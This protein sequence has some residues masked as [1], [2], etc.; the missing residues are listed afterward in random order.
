M[1]VRR[2]AREVADVAAQAVLVEGLDDGGLVDDLGAGEVEQDGARLHERELLHGDHAVGRV[3]ERH[4]DGE[5]VGLLEDLVHVGG[6]LDVGGQLPGVLDRHGRVEADDVEAEAEGRV[7][8]LDADGAQADDAEGAAGQLEA[9]ELLLAGLDGL[10]HGVSV[11]VVEL[12]GVAGRGDEVAGGDE[13][14]REDELLDSVRVGAGRVEDR[15][16]ELGH[17]GDRDVVRAG[18]G[19]AD[20]EQG[21]GNLHVVQLGG[22]DEEGGGLLDAGADLVEGVGEA[23]QA[24]AVDRVE[25]LDLEGLVSHRVSPG[26]EGFARRVR[27]GC[28]RTRPCTR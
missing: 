9:L 3:D 6:A 14:A 19:A 17:P 25:G 13:D 20:R 15:D 7:G 18:A 22:A 16:A 11:G 4:V 26:A 23:G 24:R 1:L 21:G 10:G 27:R 5:D 28:A 12:V 8:D 2:G